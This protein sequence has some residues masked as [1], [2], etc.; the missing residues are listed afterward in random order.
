MA[1][2]L[3]F[4]AGHRAYE[5]IRADG[6][7]PDTVQM[8]VGASGAAKWLVLHG[9]ESAIFGQWFSGRT[10]PLHLY[11]TSIGSW[12]S[13]AAARSNPESGFTTLAR[14]YIHQYYQ[15]KITTEQVAR[16]TDRILKEFLGPGVPEE[17]L[18]HPYCRLHL[19]SVRCRGLLAS[20]H[21]RIEMAGLLAAWLAN[22]FSRRLFQRFCL[23]TLFYDARTPPP[24]SSSGEFVGGEFPLTTANF[25]QALLA[26]GSIPCVMKSVRTIGGAPPGAYRD[27]GLFHYHPAFGFLGGQD[28]VVLYPHFYSEVTMGW[29]DKGRKSRIAD[30][31]R[32]AD[33]LLL[34]PAP[35]FVAELPFSRIPDRR[36]F[37]SLAGRDNERVEAWNRA[38]TMSRRLGECFLEAVESGAIREL[39]QRIP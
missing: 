20:D 39:V 32:L 33:V 9:L 35:Q 19:S 29:L 3:L 17:V 25:R 15:G 27:G 34:A 13:A 6:L 12:K 22:R 37:V 28:G 23:P 2:D 18:A 14:A 16:E 31:H 21:P 7:S 1:S 4:L 36:D 24:F 10:R 26:S 8:V 5:R 30:G 11:G 38:V